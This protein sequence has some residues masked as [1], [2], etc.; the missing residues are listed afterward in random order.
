M[1]VEHFTFMNK[2]NLSKTVTLVA[3]LIILIIGGFLRI[4]KIDSTPPSLNWDETAV[5][6]NAWTI[7]NYGKDEWGKDFPVSFKSFG[8]EKLPV[9]IY[10]TAIFVKLFGLTPLSTRLPS[11]IFGI[12]SI[13]M[14]YLLAK[15]LFQNKIVGLIAAFVLAL[16]P[17]QFSFSRFNHELNFAIFFFMFGIW[18]F[19]KSFN[20]KKYLLGLSFLSFCLSFLS[21]NASKI[22]VPLMVVLLVALFHKDLVKN[23]INLLVSLCFIVILIGTIFLNSELLGLTRAQ[24]TSFSQDEI[25]N[26]KLYKKTNN[27]YL[28][29]F[30]LAFSKYILYFNQSYLFE[31]GDK[32]PILSTQYSGQFLK[33]DQLFLIFGV[34]FIIFE[35]SK[36]KFNPKTNQVKLMVFLFVWALVAPIPGSF[37][38]EAPHSARALFMIGSWH[39]IIS[40][41]IYRLISLFKYLKFL[42]SKIPISLATILFVFLYLFSA[43]NYLVDYFEKYSQRYAIEWQYG[44]RESVEYTKDHPELERVFVTDLR[45]QPY[46][47]FLYF[48]KTPPSKLLET[49]VYND[50]DKNKSFNNISS[51][52]KYFFGGWDTVESMP[53]PNI[54]YVL[55][56]S[57]FDGLRHKNEFNV[58]KEVKLPNGSVAF[59][60]VRGL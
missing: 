50:S 27:L 35:A 14:I 9:H 53:I 8:E 56:S 7:A 52:D 5:G 12:L 24:Q 37:S 15:E 3:L 40:Y 25:K 17:F 51:F 11:A 22:V 46:I 49:V 23:K 60:L 41:G 33:I 20:T 29:T 21:Y 4:Y 45:S 39:I 2:F 58:E 42:N 43:K 48:L 34:V 31:K 1:V 54:L 32:N 19:L 55:T 26:T 59:Y 6:Y 13:L 38:N 10:T 47:F 16:S 28:G 30:D 36:K 44:M 57:E 18:L